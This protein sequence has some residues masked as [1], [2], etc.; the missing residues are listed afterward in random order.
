MEQ[1]PSSIGENFF[2][3]QESVGERFSNIVFSLSCFF[4]GVGIGFYSG[5]D[6]AAVCFAFFPGVVVL[7]S[8]FAILVRKST[9]EKIAITK[10]L[11]GVVEETLSAIK[12]ISAFANEDKEVEKFRKL[13]LKV[14]AV[15]HRQEVLIS[16]LIGLFRMFIF[17]FYV[18]SLYLAS[19]FLEKHKTNPSKNYKRYDVGALLSVLIS[20]M[21]GMIMIFGLSPNIQALIR[22]KVVGRMIFD[23]IEREPKIR[24][25]EGCVSD[26]DVTKSI[27]FENVSFRYPTAPPNV[28]N[29]LDNVNF[30]IKA[31]STTAIVGP[32]GSGKST[33][34]QMIERFYEPLNGEIYFD[35]INLKK[36]K[37]KTL[38]ETIGYVSQ[39]PVLILGTVRDNILFGNKDATEKEMDYALKQANATFVYD[40]EDK[41][42]TYIGSASVLNLSGGQKQRI[43][44]ARALI[45]NPKLLILDEATS[46]LD[47]K[48]EKEV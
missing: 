19:I 28:R 40:M 8:I 9:I 30:E 5:A 10:V 7:T 14:K 32:S 37:L 34:V 42:D 48:S 24:D 18:Y 23:V 38:R 46:A 2:T 29:V 43:A 36:I 13:A 15:A 6:F 33:I 1:L 35:D 27:R 17:G 31:G 39:E 16:V 4:S 12:L 44:I 22:A 21:A 45:K 11:G 41:L 47:P 26:F 3:I 20:M 25:I